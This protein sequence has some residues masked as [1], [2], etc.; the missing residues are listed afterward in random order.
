MLEASN[1]DVSDAD[2]MQKLF[3]P[4]C[5]DKT[6]RLDVSNL[7]PMDYSLPQDL[8]SKPEDSKDWFRYV[9][10]DSLKQGKPV[11]FNTCAEIFNAKKPVTGTAVPC[12]PHAVVIAG[13]R[14]SDG[15]C[16]VMIRNS[17]GKDTIENWIDEDVAAAN[18]GGML[19]LVNVKK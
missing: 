11:Q 10:V 5:A 2:L 19:T 3:A 9:S 12:S 15:K 18:N 7:E 14:Y 16:Q 4:E 1:E 6:K 13:Y 8:K 17:W